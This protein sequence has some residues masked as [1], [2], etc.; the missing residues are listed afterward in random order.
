MKK[1]KANLGITV[2]FVLNKVLKM[3]TQKPNDYL[4]RKERTMGS[5]PPLGAT[6]CHLKNHLTF[7]FWGGGTM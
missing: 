7:F 2:H 6:P 1:T 3:L 4:I 5:G